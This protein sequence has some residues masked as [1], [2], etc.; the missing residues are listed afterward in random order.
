MVALSKTSFR[1][2]NVMIR[3]Q[4]PQ[5][6]QVDRAMP[7][8][9]DTSQPGLF[10]L[11]PV[12]TRTDRPAPSVLDHGDD[13]LSFPPLAINLVGK[14]PLPLAAQGLRRHTALRPSEDR[15]IGLEGRVE[16]IQEGHRAMRR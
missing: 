7:V 13:H 16:N 8:V 4:A 10:A 5:A 14:T 12:A 1:D 11:W 3:E 6:A 15:R 2:W 9:H